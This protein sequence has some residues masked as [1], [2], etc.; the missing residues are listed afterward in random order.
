MSSKAVSSSA[1]ARYD[2]SRDDLDDR[3]LDLLSVCGLESF[4]GKIRRNCPQCGV[5]LPAA[6]EEIVQLKEKLEY[7]EAKCRQQRVS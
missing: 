7:V 6:V 3:P 2:S 5:Y 4:R 1:S